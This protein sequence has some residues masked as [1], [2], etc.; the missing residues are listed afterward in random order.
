MSVL[1]KAFRL[2]S[3]LSLTNEKNPSQIPYKPSKTVL[4]GPEKKYFKREKP[5]RHGVSSVKLYKLLSELEAEKRA[6]L[7]N[8]M[9][10]KDGAVI[11]EASVPGYSINTMHLSHSMSKTVTGMAIGFLVDEGKL[12]LQTRLVDIFPEEKPTEKLFDTITVESLLTMS[13]G[14]KLSEAGSVTVSE[15]TSEFFASKLS[16]APNTEFKYNSM[17]SYILAKIVSRISGVTL[18]EFLKD[19]LFAPLEIE[20][21]FWELGPEGIEKGGWG[22]YMSLESWAKLGVLMLGRGKWNGKPILSEKWVK[23]ACT[24][25]K[26]A[27]EALGDFNY[28]YQLWVSRSNEEFLF[29]GMLGQ[30]VWVSPKNN[31]VVAINSGNNELFQKSPALEI[32]RKHLSAENLEIPYDRAGI[33]LLRE[34]ERRF[35]ES[36]REVTPLLP[37]KGLRYLLSLGKATPYNTAFDSLLGTYGFPENNHGIL[38]VFVRVMQN[39]Y[40]GGI[41]SFKI[42]RDGDALRFT[43]REGGVNYSFHIGLYGYSYTS[44]DFCGEKYIIGALAEA[45]KDINGAPVFKINLI[46]PEI[47]NSTVIKITK[48]TDAVANIKLA[49]TPNQ[50]LAMP[51]IESAVAGSKLL[52]FAVSMIEKKFGSDFIENRL[53]GT[54]E[55]SFRAINVNA[56]DYEDRIG[57]MNAAEEERIASMKILTMLISRFTR[58]E[59]DD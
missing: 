19:R 38:P 8:I 55:P 11:S 36:R 39:N 34:K 1:K 35:F 27:S 56:P 37:K 52:S 16:F 33:T 7:H 2:V 45:S 12:D 3:A 6:N 23:A 15:W 47:P 42:E 41:E 21:Y 10:I 40:Q 13:S 24:A 58:T 46:F 20:N 50:H 5:E 44:L 51:F 31:L 49:E 9:V 28:G 25:H 43:S 53:T 29:N 4:S 32:I 17:N 54:F 26:E 48:E 14:V 22:L 30:N 57:E 18:T 59:E